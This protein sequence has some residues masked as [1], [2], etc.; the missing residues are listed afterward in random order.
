MSD[1]N[2][3]PESEVRVEAKPDETSG[4][5]VDSKIKIYDPET[6]EVILEQRA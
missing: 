2:E 3:K 5:L 6:S 1:K 4:L